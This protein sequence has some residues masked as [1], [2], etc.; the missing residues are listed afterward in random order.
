MSTPHRP[1]SA[2]GGSSPRNAGPRPTS[3]DAAALPT[4][5]RFSTDEP[6]QPPLHHRMAHDDI[7]EETTENVREGPLEIESLDPREEVT[8]PMQLE[9][10]RTTSIPRLPSSSASSGN[11]KRGYSLRRQLFFKQAQNDSLN[12]ASHGSSD[13]L[14]LEAVPKPAPLALK[15]EVGTTRQVEQ[16]RT[17]Q[18]SPKWTAIRNWVVFHYQETRKTILRLHPL[19]PTKEGRK[20]RVD[21]KAGD[22][23]ID[24]RTGKRYVGNSIR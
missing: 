16:P 18:S 24:E 13:D 9:A 19:P 22:P 2:D 4:H 8:L 1:G 10:P 3:L 21:L 11:R 17:K 5:V 20:I 12:P 23:G 15:P 7:T 6:R 14:E